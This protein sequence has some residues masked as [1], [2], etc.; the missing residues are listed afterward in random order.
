[1][2]MA[3]SDKPVVNTMLSETWAQGYSVCQLL[4]ALGRQSELRHSA[5]VPLA[6][7]VLGT[8]AQGNLASCHTLHTVRERALSTCLYHRTE[9]CY[10]CKS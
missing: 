9:T 3:V 8:S 7:K 10:K 5:G 1:M 4:V 6:A 2:Q